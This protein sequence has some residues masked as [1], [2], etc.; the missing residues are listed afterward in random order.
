MET[1]RVSCKTDI[2]VRYPVINGTPT[3]IYLVYYGPISV[4]ENVNKH[5]FKTSGKY[6]RDLW[7][8]YA[9]WAHSVSVT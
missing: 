4:T 8:E 6:F 9:G 7:G 5:F 2:K 3:L 1:C